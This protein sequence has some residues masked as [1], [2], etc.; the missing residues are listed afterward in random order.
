MR[1]KLVSV[2]FLL[3]LEAF[4]QSDGAIEMI[5]YFR[6]SESFSMGPI[7]KLKNK[8]HWYIE[9]RYNYEERQTVSLYF[10]KSYSRQSKFSYTIVPIVGG[11]V[12]R[13]KGGSIGVN[14]ELS[15]QHFYL[16]SQSQYTASSS[17]E[18]QDF[19]FSWT[20]L[21]YE[22]TPWCF[23]GLSM[24]PTY[25]TQSRRNSAVS[26]GVVAG[27]VWGKWTIPF[28]VFEPLVPSKAMFVCSVIRDIKI[29]NKKSH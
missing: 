1:T 16:S 4:A 3:S 20:E 8:R 17:R 2:A 28:Y 10:G 25:Y 9:G 7:V 18:A 21:G 27:I 22:I 12:G 19:F 23:A 29:L 26:P 5:H 24:Q 14:M 11:V 13:F 15:Y 6:P